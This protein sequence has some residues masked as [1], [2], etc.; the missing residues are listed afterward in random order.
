MK[1]KLNTNIKE[2]PILATLLIAVIIGLICLIIFTIK[3]YEP[4]RQIPPIIKIEVPDMYEGLELS[5]I[6]Y[7]WFYKGQESLQE[8]N[9]DPN[10]YDYSDCTVY[11][12]YTGLNP[13]MKATP[14][15][16]FKS[17]T[18]T[19]YMYDSDTNEYKQY[20][21]DFN[22]FKEYEKYIHLNSSSGTSHT[23]VSVYTMTYG[24]QGTASYVVK[25]IEQDNYH[26]GIVK[27]Y[28]GIGLEE[29]EKIKELISKLSFGIYLE[30]VQTEDGKLNL[31]YQY[32]VS[33]DSINTIAIALFSLIDDLKEIQF[34]HL[35]TEFVTSVQENNVYTTKQIQYTEPRIVTRESLSQNLNLELSNL[36]E[37]LGL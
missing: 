30:D 29:K 12:S 5:P 18:K 31:I 26:L 3:Y 11:K 20:E 27:E 2:K 13:V 4:Q 23:F 14:K 15:Y 19:T 24:N 6:A 21:T 9:F 28:K 34:S 8:L 33:N 22:N 35:N 17:M 32:K 36:K 7:D 25:V 16:R 1:T 10:N 37:N